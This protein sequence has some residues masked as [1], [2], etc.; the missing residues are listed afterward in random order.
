MIKSVKR[1]IILT[2][3]A[4]TVNI[5]TQISLNTTLTVKLNL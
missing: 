4:S 1:T 3:H 5:A 2:D